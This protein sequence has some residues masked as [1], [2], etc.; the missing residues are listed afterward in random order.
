M[1]AR[2]KEERQ[3]CEYL[4]MKRKKGVH[5]GSCV[6]YNLN[7]FATSLTWMP[8]GEGEGGCVRDLGYRLR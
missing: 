4:E 1:C 5:F 6:I 7:P 3:L 2:D 8:V